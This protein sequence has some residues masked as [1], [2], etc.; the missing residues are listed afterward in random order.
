MIAENRK[1]FLSFILRRC[2]EPDED[3]WW[4]KKFESPW[5]PNEENHETAAVRRLGV[6]ADIRTEYLQSTTIQRQSA[7]W[8]YIRNK[9]GHYILSYGYALFSGRLYDSRTWQ[10]ATSAPVYVYARYSR[11]EFYWMSQ[12]ERQQYRD[13][14]INH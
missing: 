2:Q 12:R 13:H 10:T 4:I 1:Y 3:K 6:P 5:G 8:M 9:F 7:L 11:M 14:E